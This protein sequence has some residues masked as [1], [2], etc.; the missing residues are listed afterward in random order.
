[1]TKARYTDIQTVMKKCGESGCLFLCLL[2]ICE[3]VLGLELDFITSYHL[4][5]NKGLIDSDFY[6]KDSLEILH[7]LTG[8]NW[9]REVKTFLPN[10]IP[11][12][13]YTVEVW[14]Y[15]DTS[16]F[17]RRGYDVI[18]NSQTVAKG[19]LVYYYCYSWR[20]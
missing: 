9:I 1:M 10:H 17:R 5:F 16:H 8:K 20:E 15:K 13:M 4:C 7:T 6:C 12:E 19:K 14:K 11:D 3:E 2:S 18:R